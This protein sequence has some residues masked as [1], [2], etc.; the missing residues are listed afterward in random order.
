MVQLSDYFIVYNPR[1]IPQKRRDVDFTAATINHVHR[2]VKLSTK[3]EYLG[4]DS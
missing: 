4:G 2:N 1:G 3:P